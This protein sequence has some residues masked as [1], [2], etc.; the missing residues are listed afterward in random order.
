[1]FAA[2]K[3]LQA[4]TAILSAFNTFWGHTERETWSTIKLAQDI[5]FINPEMVFKFVLSF[6]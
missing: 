3:M 5:P 2:E 6:S 4:L 1:M